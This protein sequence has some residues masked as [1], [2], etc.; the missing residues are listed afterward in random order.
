MPDVKALRALFKG[1]D[2]DKFLIRLKLTGRVSGEIYNTRGVL[3]E[4]LSE[5]VTHLETDTGELI[6]EITTE[7][8]DR[9]FT[10]GSFP[11]SLLM[12]LTRKQQNLLSLQMA[13]DLIQEVKQR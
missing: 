10:Q 6:R 2:R 11:H 4:E 7:D 12:E 5:C 13:Y 3:L 1:L 9:E 8:I